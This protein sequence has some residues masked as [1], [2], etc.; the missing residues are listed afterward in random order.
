MADGYLHGFTAEEQQRLLTQADF[1][2]PWVF[3]DVRL[4]AAGALLELG[5]GVGAETRFLL[6]RT[7]NGVTVRE[8]KV[9]SS[10][11]WA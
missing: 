11:A 5:A 1:L 6:E 4:P 3:R 9:Q 7:D 8:D 10:Q 2:A